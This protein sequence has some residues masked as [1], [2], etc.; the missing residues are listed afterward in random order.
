MFGPSLAA[1]SQERRVIA[2]ELQG[3][4]HTADIDRPLTYE[5]MADDIAA[6]MKFLG[7]EQADVMGYSLGAGVA[8]Q[9]AIRHP[10]S[11]RKLV[12]VSAAFKRD[13]WYPEVLAV[14][15]QMGPVAAEQMKQSPRYKL[16][17]NVNWAVLFTKLGDLL[18][19]DYDWSKQVAAIKAPTMIV[20]ADADAVR[21]AHV[22]EFF[23]LLGGGQ[24][25]AGLDGSGRTENQLA[26]LPGLTH[27]NTSSAPVLT[28]VVAPFLDAPVS[29]SK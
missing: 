7:I 3:H 13:G 14:M 29:V 28:T 4:G 12:V 23:G 17:P 16:Y 11:V 6:L 15:A 27:Y 21:P 24:K 18:R 19:K 2:V 1:L 8:L 25:D 10:E 22:I 20:F 9:T 5:A 26:I